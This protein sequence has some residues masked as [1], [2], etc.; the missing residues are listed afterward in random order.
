VAKKTFAV[1]RREELSRERLF[2]DIDEAVKLA[3]YLISSDAG[4]REV[5]ILQATK[6]VRSKDVPIE[7]VDLNG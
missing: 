4:K 3:T 1:Y 6:A 7:V 5:L 2:D